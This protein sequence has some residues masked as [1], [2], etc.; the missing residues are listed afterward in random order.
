[1]YPDRQSDSY[2]NDYWLR[3][4]DSNNSVVSLN[5]STPGGTIHNSERSAKEGHDLVLPGKADYSCSSQ[6]PPP[7]STM[8]EIEAETGARPSLPSVIS[9]TTE[10]AHAILAETASNVSGDEQP[11]TLEET[12]YEYGY[13]PPKL[14]VR[15]S[16]LDEET[17]RI[18]FSDYIITS[19]I[20]TDDDVPAI[21]LASCRYEDYKLLPLMQYLTTSMKAWAKLE[22]LT[23][24]CVVF[25]LT[26][27][28]EKILA[29]PNATERAQALSE[30]LIISKPFSG[31]YG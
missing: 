31:E 16:V 19:S 20:V 21:S 18:L 25:L 13:P 8:S 17:R 6:I 15:N 23:L 28:T 1:M 2:T 7:S 5:S 27:F 22:N 11:T 4:A 10:D 12:D 3:Y 9:F 30:T 29:I 26:V 14:S 24:E